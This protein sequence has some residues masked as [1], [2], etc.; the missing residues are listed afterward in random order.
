[1]YVS[2]YPRNGELKQEKV[3][4]NKVSQITGTNSLTGRKE[5]FLFLRTYI[6]T[7]QRL[8]SLQTELEKFREKK[9]S[10][11]TIL[12]NNSSRCRLV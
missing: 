12:V 2:C 10:G 1:M 11:E 5:I 8:T 4:L 9:G 3:H 6:S 7:F